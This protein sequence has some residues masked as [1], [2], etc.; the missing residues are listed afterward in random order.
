MFACDASLGPV[1][2]PSGRSKDDLGL[3]R[4]EELFH[5]D[6]THSVGPGHV[7]YVPAGSLHQFVNTGTSPLTFVCVILRQDR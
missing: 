6:Q 2:R 5:E 3:D 4:E 1:A 7:A